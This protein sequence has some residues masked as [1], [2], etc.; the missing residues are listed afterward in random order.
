MKVCTDACLFGAFAAERIQRALC[1]TKLKTQNVLDIGSGTGLLSLMFAQ[2]NNNAIIDAVEIDDAAA[3]QARENFNNS[4]WKEILNTHHDTIQHFAL[5]VNKKYDI[6]I[7]NPPFYP[8]DLK[9]LNKQRNTALHSDEHCLEEL[10]SIVDA[11]LKDDGSFFVLL[12]YHRTK[13]F[14]ELMLKHKL[15]V[16]E[17][18]F[19]KQTSTHNYFRTIFWVGRNAG[20][21]NEQEIIIINDEKEYSDEFKKLLKEYYLRL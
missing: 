8:N 17:K 21:Y 3:N 10:I 12:P 6:I 13:Y 15:F 20:V 7:C 9:S 4:V 14:E 19:I 5:S 18:V 11:L 1:G 2:K 16:R